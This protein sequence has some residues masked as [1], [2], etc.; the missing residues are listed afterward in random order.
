MACLEWYWYCDDNELSAV[1]LSQDEF[2]DEIE[3]TN[4]EKLKALSFFNDTDK[5]VDFRKSYVVDIGRAK[6]LNNQLKQQPICTQP[7]AYIYEPLNELHITEGNITITV[8]GDILSDCDY[9][10]T[11]TDNIKIGDTNDKLEELFTY[12]VDDTY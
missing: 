4:I 3:Q 10:Y 2:H 7:V 12:I 5:A 6:K 1:A 11:E 8:N 9:E